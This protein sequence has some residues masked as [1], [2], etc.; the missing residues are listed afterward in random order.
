[1]AEHA[2]AAAVPELLLRLRLSMLLR[3]SLLLLRLR[4]SMLLRLGCMLLLLRAVPERAA[5]AG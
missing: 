1:M 3:L 4:L 5:A 2:V